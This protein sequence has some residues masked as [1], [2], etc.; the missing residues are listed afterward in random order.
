MYNLTP[1][2]LVLSTLMIFVVVMYKITNVDATHR[3]ISHPMKKRYVVIK[4]IESII[5][6]AIF[7]CWILSIV[8]YAKIPSDLAKVSLTKGSNETLFLFLNISVFAL[9][10]VTTFLLYFVLKSLKRLIS[11][12]SE[13]NN[14]QKHSTYNNL[15]HA[16]DNGV[17]KDMIENFAILQRSRNRIDLSSEEYLTLLA[18]CISEDEI[19]LSKDIS[20]CVKGKETIRKSSPIKKI[21]KLVTK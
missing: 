16:I 14:Q 20:N 21:K 9:S 19:E 7:V 3:N 5:F 12:F 2:I 18:A 13:Y 15:I 11:Y 10:V 1:A 8:N 17:S 6:V 4:L